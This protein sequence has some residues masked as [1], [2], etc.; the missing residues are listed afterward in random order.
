MEFLK[1]N[2]IQTNTSVIV[3]SN[4]TTVDNMMLRDKTLQYLSSGFNDDTTISTM[5]INFDSTQSVSRIAMLGMNL[6]EFNIYYDGVTANTFAIT[7]TSATNTSQWSTNSETS[8]YIMATAVGCTSV[9][10]D[11]KTTQLANSEKAIGYLAVSSVELDFARIPSAKNYKPV[12][13]SKEIVHKLSDGGIRINYL[14]T[15]FSASIKFKNIT[16][17]FRDNLKTVYDKKEEFLFTAFGTSTSWDEIFYTVVWPGSFD[18]Y[19]YSD[20]AASSG[21]SGS[22]KLAEVPE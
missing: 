10:I 18:F 6:K 17:S 9:S 21:F 22:I 11:M 2:Y 4:T 12:L 8:L 16:T 5:V 15:K 1:A 20:N 7:S 3:N 19:K 14:S 13:N